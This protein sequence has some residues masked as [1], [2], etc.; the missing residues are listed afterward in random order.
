MSQKMSTMLLTAIVCCFAAATVSAQGWVLQ[1][2]P[3]ELDTSAI[4][5]KVQFVSPTEGWI[6]EGHGRLLHTTNAGAD[7]SVVTPFPDDT[8]VSVSDPSISMSWVNQTHGWKMNW[9]GTGFADAHGAVIHKTAD[10]GVTWEKKVLTTETGAL[11]M[12]V[13]FVDTSNG[14]ATVYYSAGDSGRTLR[15]T[16][17]G[18]SWSPIEPGGIF[19]FVDPNNGWA[20]G[21]LGIYHFI[22]NTTNGGT[23]WSLQY[24]DST[25]GAF[26]AIQ[27]TDLNNGWVVGDS[28][29]ILHTTNGGSNWS[30]VTNAG[31]HPASK[32]KCLYFL[33]ADTGW[34]GT[35]DGEPN[36]NPARIILHT[37]DGGSNWTK[38][39]LP[40][41]GAVFSIFFWDANNGWYAGE[42]GDSLSY[43]GII[44]HTTNGGTAV[45][46][47]PVEPFNGYCFKLGQNAPN[48]F[49]QATT[50]NYQL[51]KSGSVNLTIYNTAGQLV[52][53]LV[54]AYRQPGSYTVK[55]DC[56]G[57]GNRKVANGVYMV[58]MESDGRAVTSKMVVVR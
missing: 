7:W 44:A 16:D 53:T 24:S 3:L 13:Q 8:V 23:G 49:K 1:T 57:N 5:G 48:P 14:W 28:G 55:W 38:Q 32:S 2:N 6:S 20:F 30:L 21:T 50:I 9:L 43:S 35:N 56:S 58:R 25:P 33:N 34:I 12:Q 46:G 4:L 52:K 31:I 22:L 19:C 10:G 18:N 54:N 11:G 26:S 29:K 51:T 42:Y 40:I 41:A 39:T 17:G 36:N 27:F 47:N 45:A 15:S 37:D